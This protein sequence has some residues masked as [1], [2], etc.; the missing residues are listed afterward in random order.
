MK[1]PLRIGMTPLAFAIFAW[2]LEPF[3]VGPRANDNGRGI[4]K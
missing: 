2:H 4:A 3:T 1:A